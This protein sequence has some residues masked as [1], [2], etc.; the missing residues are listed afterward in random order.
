MIFEDTDLSS[1]ETIPKYNLSLAVKSVYT[2]RKVCD[3]LEQWAT[4]F[5]TTKSTKGEYYNSIS[6]SSREN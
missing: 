6:W 3:C 2:E 5:K 4:N 1:S